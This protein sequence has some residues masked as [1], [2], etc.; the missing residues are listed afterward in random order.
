NYWAGAVGVNEIDLPF[1]QDSETAYQLY[2]TGDLD[3]MGSQQ[4]PVPSARVPEVSSSPDFHN[5]A[6]FA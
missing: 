1:V 3:I 2:R 5:V 4:N 6:S